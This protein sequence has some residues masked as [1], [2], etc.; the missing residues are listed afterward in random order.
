MGH[1]AG[2]LLIAEQAATAAATAAADRAFI[3]GNI[4]PI[5]SQEYQL[6]ALHWQVVQLRQHLCAAASDAQHW[7]YRAHMAETTTAAETAKA[8][9]GTVPTIANGP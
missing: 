9:A 5:T 7:A 2:L 6:Q 8:T 1:Q 3:P 4:A